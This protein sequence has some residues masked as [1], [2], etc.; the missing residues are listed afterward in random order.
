MS[1]IIRKD[2]NSVRDDFNP[3]TKAALAHRAGFCCSK[4]ECRALTAGPSN[5]GPLA[6]TNIGVAAHITSASPSGARYNSSL[7]SQERSSSEN[8]IWLCQTHAKEIDDDETLYTVELLQ[9]WQRQAEAITRS[10]L[11]QPQG[12]MPFYVEIE[13]SLHRDSNGGLIVGGVTN[14]P[15]KTKLMINLKRYSNQHLLGQ[16]KVAVY[17][18]TFIAGPFTNKELPH[19]HAWYSVE[20]LAHFNRPWQQPD[21]VLSIIGMNG[22]GI[23]GQFVQDVHPELP[24][25]EKRVFGVF[26]LVP[27]LGPTDT[28]PQDVDLEKAINLVKTSLL[29]IDGKISSEPVGEVVSQFISASGISTRDGWSA[30]IM[31]NGS[32][33]VTFL[34]WDGDSQETAEW[35]VVIQSGEVHYFNL[36]AKYMSYN[37]K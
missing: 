33:Q 30:K 3:K 19:P 15:E 1:T 7:T 2:Q 25:S 4:P 16:T 14:L 6:L 21:V 35:N 5:D 34:F 23:T 13:F 20:I 24:E 18:S 11:G 9:E 10:L 27:P 26:N 37:S 22:K 28:P 17:N 36:S 31:G 12:Q 8:G 32:V 29:E